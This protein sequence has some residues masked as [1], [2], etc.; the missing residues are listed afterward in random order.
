MAKRGRKTSM[1]SLVGQ[2]VALLVNIVQTA[3]EQTRASVA[4]TPVKSAKTGKRGR[5]KGSKNKAK[6][7]G[8]P[9][10]KRGPGRPKGSKNKTET[11]APVTATSDEP[12]KRGRK[13]NAVTQMV[14]DGL[15]ACKTEA[16]KKQA[17]DIYHAVVEGVRVASPRKVKNLLAEIASMDGRKARTARRLIV[18][19]EEQKLIKDLKAEGCKPRV[20]A[21]CFHLEPSELS[22]SLSD[23]VIDVTEPKAEEPKAEK[24]TGAKRGRP[25][26]SKNKVVKTMKKTTIQ[27]PV[28]ATKTE[29][30]S[31]P[32]VITAPAAVVVTTPTPAPVAEPAP[33]AATPA[34]Q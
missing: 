30:A 12:K 27:K 16:L 34:A 26:G 32:A 13:P 21:A 31:R 17:L 19:P 28:D 9:K 22:A 2:M 23:K 25:K 29:D 11:V 18:S 20:L 10:G 6:K 8:R 24:P 4:E 15:A 14:L 33:E 1:E 7:V 3:V 5:P